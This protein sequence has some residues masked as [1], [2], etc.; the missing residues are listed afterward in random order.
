MYK[1]LSITYVALL[2]SACTSHKEYDSGEPIDTAE[3]VQVHNEVPHVTAD[4]T[5]TVLMEQNVEYAQGL[6]HDETSDTPFAIPLYL[7]VYYPDN[8]LTADPSTCSFTE[9][10][11]VV[12]T[13]PELLKWPIIMHLGDG[14][15]PL[16]IIEQQK[17][18]VILK[19]S[20]HVKVNSVI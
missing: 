8:E 1:M 11:L 14:C 18:C 7:D 19:M 16:L 20:L 9:G 3:D 12:Q 4:S 5:Y 10:L 15:L 2:V 13:K 17:S 6:A